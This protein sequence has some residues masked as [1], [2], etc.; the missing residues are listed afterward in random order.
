MADA[1]PFLSQTAQT[2]AFAFREYFR[3][4]VVAASF[5]KSRLVPAKPA[6]SAA[7]DQSSL[8]VAKKDKNPT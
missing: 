2:A 3:P 1:K 8:E 5:L 4:L 7:E 6:E